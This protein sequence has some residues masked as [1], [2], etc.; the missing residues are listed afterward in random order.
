[1]AYLMIAVI[2]KDKKVVGYRVFDAESRKEFRDVPAADLKQVIQ[3]GKAE[4][5]NL[6]IQNDELVGTNGSIERYPR[7]SNGI[8]LNETS[9][10]VVLNQLGDVGYTVVDYN[11][12]VKRAKTSD[13]VEYA[14]KSGIANG[15]VVMKD[16]IEFIS[17]IA[18]TYT[19]ERI[20]ASKIKNDAETVRAH[21]ALQGST[22][23]AGNNIVTK[24]TKVEVE[25]EI[26]D[27]DVFDVMTDDQKAVL[28]GYYVWY[29]V[30]KYK[31]LAKNI[32]FD[33]GLGK[34]ERLAELRGDHEWEFGGV[35]DNGYTGIGK[36]T[37]NHDIRYEYYAVPTDD[38]DNKDAW[39]IF[40]V[41]CAADFF[42]IK[43]EDMSNLGKTRTIMS[44]ELK[45]IS[46]ILANEQE[47]LY[48]AKT[49]MLYSILRK[50]NSK[51][52]ILEAFGEKMGYALL[53]FIVVKLPLPMSLIIECTKAIATRVPDFLI[54]V[55]P[56][57]TRAIREIYYSS[58]TPTLIAGGKEYLNFMVTNKIEGDYAYDPLNDEIK[59]RDIGAYNKQT[60]YMR[61][62]LLSAIRSKVLCRD[63]TYEEL[64]SYLY[65]VNEL[66][67]HEKEIVSKF[68]G[69]D[70]TDNKSAK[71]SNTSKRM[72]VEPGLDS[73][74]RAGLVTIYNSV[75]MADGHNLYQSK[76]VYFDTTVKMI[77]NH[78]Y[79]NYLKG[80]L[81]SVEGQ[82]FTE[83]L[84]K[85]YTNCLGGDLE[86]ERLRKVEEDRKEKERLENER[87]EQERIEKEKVLR[88]QER[89]DRE[90]REKIRIDRLAREKREREA[91]ALELSEARANNAI[92]T[93]A[94]EKEAINK[95]EKPEDKTNKL[96]SLIDKH[97]GVIADGVEIAKSILDYGKDYDALSPKQK[98]RIDNTIKI[99]ERAATNEAV[100]GDPS[101]QTIP[102][103]NVDDEENKSYKLDEHPEINTKVQRVIKLADSVE[104]QEVLKKHPHVLKI[105]YTITRSNKASDKQLKHINKA[106]ELIDQA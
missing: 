65:C 5:L 93:K 13:V 53:S 1:M 98:W 39:I 75:L 47:R 15:K 61:E 32:R 22:N 34:A 48:I 74:L 14:K 29:T 55:F 71:V 30:E 56:E 60:R 20:V 101:T 23:N 102:A 81:K 11:G 6:G 70:Y 59:R 69:T 16:N 92:D 40:G 42:N 62:R 58:N 9:P 52:K 41:V 28:K 84:D 25:D 33:I 31:E 8:L 76:P 67:Q 63:F 37:M 79:I 99:Y 10:L 4:V 78:R 94:D 44:Q 91:K 83:A 2:Q 105:A 103:G 50:L 106:I 100:Q 51:E 3:S 38:R 86:K 17:S 88:E 49:P 27:S 19:M 85:L 7:L 95:S 73:V 87:L 26:E 21:I 68:K 43:P 89:Q 35:W 66:V 80:D 82:P 90:D 97:P 24:H 18:G 96:K 72:M 104:M 45:L 46:D 57:Y 54:S 36:C 12:V 77:S 64:E